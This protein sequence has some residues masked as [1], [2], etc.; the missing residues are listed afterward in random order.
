ML[1][2]GDDLQSSGHFDNLTLSFFIELALPLLRYA[3]CNKEVKNHP[4]KFIGTLSL[5]A[6]RL[7]YLTTKDK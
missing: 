7:R 6:V 5:S 1:V 2:A 4:N 3:P